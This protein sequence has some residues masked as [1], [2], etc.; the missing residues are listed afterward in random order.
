MKKSIENKGILSCFLPLKRYRKQ[1]DGV[2]AIEFAL[3]FFPFFLLIM[4]I[5][6]LSL[7][8]ASGVTLEGAA[9][10]ASRLVRTGQAQNAAD[11]Q[12]TFEDALCAQVGALVQCDDI[13]YEVVNLGSDFS[14][15]QTTEP[16]YDADGNLQ[17]SGFDA[18]A[19]E[20][21][22]MIRAAYRHEF[23]LPL[24]GQLLGDDTGTNS[25]LHL[26]TVVVK[27]EPYQF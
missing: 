9:T 23:L 14:T 26:S 11:P 5:I 6:E 19:P 24:L 8:Y 2:V 27:T 1:E 3:L 17:S 22:I 13:T 4:G 16:T 21:V 25:S 18:G 12:A 7:F 15:A 20:T 10:S